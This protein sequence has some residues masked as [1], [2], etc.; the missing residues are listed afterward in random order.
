MAQRI[1][2]LLAFMF[3]TLNANQNALTAYKNK[4]YKK[5]FSLYEKAAKKGDSVSQSALSFLYF[6]GVGVSKNTNLGLKWLKKS[7][8][9][10]NATAQYDLGMFYLKGNNVA[11]DYKQAATWLDSSAKLGNTD[12]QF[13]LALMYYKGEGV[14]ENTTKSAELLDAAATNGHIHAKQNIGRLYM[15]LLKFDKAIAWLTLNAKEGDVE[16]FYL[17]AEIYV[18]KEEFKEAAYWADRAIAKHD[19]KAQELWDKYKLGDYQ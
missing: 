18:S 10:A 12:A 14:D 16:A 4:E 7:A 6:N 2:I 19:L 17:L 15:R 3:I 9:N 13:N 11:Q 8:T 1:I 5:A